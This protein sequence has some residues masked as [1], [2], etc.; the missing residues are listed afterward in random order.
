MRKSEMLLELAKNL[1][2]KNNINISNDLWGYGK[3]RYND[4]KCIGCG[5]CEENCSEEAIKFSKMFDLPSLLKMQSS[6]NNLKKD[7]IVILIKKLSLKEPEKEIPVPDL[8]MGYGKVVIE[9]DKCGGCG[10]CQRNC[11]GEALQVE[12]V[13]EVA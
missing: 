10:N 5:K 2:V 11:P 1:G 12:K 13:L 8:V 7:V 6:N 4:E 9:K 3:I